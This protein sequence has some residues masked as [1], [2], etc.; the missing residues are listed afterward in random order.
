[1]RILTSYD[2][3][4]C[5]GFARGSTLGCIGVSITTLMGVGVANVSAGRALPVVVNP[6]RLG[7]LLALTLGLCAGSAISAMVVV[8]RVDPVTAF[9][10]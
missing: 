3:E 9:A 8:T 1:M 5:R 4:A 10:R 6:A 7:S 2:P